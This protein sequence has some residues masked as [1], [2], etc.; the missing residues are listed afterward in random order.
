MVMAALKIVL[1]EWVHCV[2]GESHHNMPHIAIKLWE[3]RKKGNLKSSQ[4]RREKGKKGPLVRRQPLAWRQ[5]TPELSR[6]PAS[7]ACSGI[8]SPSVSSNSFYW[9]EWCLMLK[10]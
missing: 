5:C 6:R 3:G 9:T 7:V 4:V 2:V 10:V 1:F 8:Q